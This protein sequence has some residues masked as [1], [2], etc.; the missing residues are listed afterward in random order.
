MSEA[1]SG[2][3]VAEM[4]ADAEAQMLNTGRILRY[5]KVFDGAGGWNEDYTPFPDP[6][7]PPLP[8][9]IAPVGRK[10]GSSS[11]GE[12]LNESSTHL[13][14]WPASTEVSA[15]DR[16]EVDGVLYSIT[17]L[18]EFGALNVTRRV[19]VRALGDRA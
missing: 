9:S 2:E 10:G 19:E 5:K 4:Q 15:D 11:G 6:A 3:E 7:D 18:R 17:A 1:I 14:S 12:R 16:C 8:C 13:T